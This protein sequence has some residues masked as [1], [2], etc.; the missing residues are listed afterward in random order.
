[1]KRI[2]YFFSTLFFILVMSFSSYSQAEVLGDA[3]SNFEDE[4][5]EVALKQYLKIIK[6][7]KIFISKEKYGLEKDVISCF[8]RRN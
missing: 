2:I 4:N 8:Q 6:K 5:Y 7:Y 3:D 1:M